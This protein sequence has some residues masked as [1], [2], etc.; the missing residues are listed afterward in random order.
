MN[1]LLGL[2]EGKL[3][4]EQENTLAIAADVNSQEVLVLHSLREAFYYAR[5]CYQSQ[6]LTDGEIFSAC[7]TALTHAARCFKP[8][9]IR[10]LG[11]AKVFI[12]GALHRTIVAQKVVKGSYKATPL[13]AEP[14]DDDAKSVE[15]PCRQAPQ[16][17]VASTEPAFDVVYLRE[18]W[19]Q[20]S[21]IFRLILS[22][23]ERMILELHFQGGLDLK[24]IGDLLGTSRSYVQQKKQTALKKIR[25]RLID[26]HKFYN[27]G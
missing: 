5:G 14:D 26:Q 16:G 18:E 13:V 20:I 3:L 19:A 25:N 2:P 1:I 23:R 8:N 6:K 12:R 15:L 22:D 21:P 7:Y 17:E 4:P 9:K 11:Y 24:E 27:R 10:F